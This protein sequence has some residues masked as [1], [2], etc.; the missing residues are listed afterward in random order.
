VLRRGRSVVDEFVRRV[1]GH[2]L[3]LA[4]LLTDC[5]VDVTPSQANFVLARFA[6]A[7]WVRDA[8]AGMGIAVRAFPDVPVLSD[9]LRITVPGDERNLHR[10]CVA[11]E[12]VLRPDGVLIDSRAVEAGQVADRLTERRDGVT[13]AAID[14]PS[15]QAALDDINASRCWFV[16]TDV[17]SVRDARQA[18]VLPLGVETPN[19]PEARDMLLAGAGRVLVNLTQLEELLP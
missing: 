11:L 17:A 15:G 13:V 3:Q 7:T 14:M 19:G 12:T 18:G 8:L 6:D 9:R 1:R 5:G 16:G 10:L 4:D 2:R